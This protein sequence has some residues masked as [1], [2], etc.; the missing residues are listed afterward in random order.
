MDDKFLIGKLC[1]I[2]VFKFDN[3]QLSNCIGQPILAQAKKETGDA[4][5]LL[6]FLLEKKTQGTF[7]P[8]TEWIET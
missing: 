7:G 8:L 6:L 1:N 4:I 5:L 2:M 3:V